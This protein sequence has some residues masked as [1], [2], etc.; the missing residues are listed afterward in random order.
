MITHKKDTR[1]SGFGALLG[2]TLGFSGWMV[3]TP[4]VAGWHIAGIAAGLGWVLL[5]L[6][7]LPLLWRRRKVIGQFRMQ[8]LQLTVA[9]MATGGFLLTAHRMRLPLPR[10]WPPLVTTDA[11]GCAWI[12]LL[13][14]LLG[15]P[16][17]LNH[18][19]VKKHASPSPSPS[20]SG[21]IG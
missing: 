17:W 11:A 3:L 4:F 7:S 8:M 14:P 16:V 12:L 5:I 1:F 2:S 19:Q 9:F 10:S 20:P 6:L 18:R 13:F 21:P 15:V